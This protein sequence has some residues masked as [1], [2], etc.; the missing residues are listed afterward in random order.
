MMQ[1]VLAQFKTMSSLAEMLLSEATRITHLHHPS[2]N[3][4]SE[5]WMITTM[6]HIL[7]LIY[8]EMI[9]I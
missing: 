9:Y 4:L 3:F 6:T 2:P 5:R 1:S 8:Q 7:I